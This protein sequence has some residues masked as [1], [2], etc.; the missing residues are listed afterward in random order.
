MTHSR[1]E[2]INNLPVNTSVFLSPSQLPTETKVV[3]YSIV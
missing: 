1:E 3:N 2:N